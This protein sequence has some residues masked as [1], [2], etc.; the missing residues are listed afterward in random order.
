MRQTAL[1]GVDR[2]LLR[3]SERKHGHERSALRSVKRGGC[4]LSGSAAPREYL[5]LG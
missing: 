5:L 2:T 4:L 1:K 3:V